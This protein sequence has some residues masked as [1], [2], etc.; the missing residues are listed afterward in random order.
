MID[1]NT[2]DNFCEI[3]D[4]NFVFAEDGLA[5][6][7]EFFGISR[8]LIAADY[9]ELSSVSERRWS[10]WDLRGSRGGI[11]ILYGSFRAEK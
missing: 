9:D 10:R 6:I 5:K 7:S 1:E 2:W 11:R 3:R 8:D 4:S